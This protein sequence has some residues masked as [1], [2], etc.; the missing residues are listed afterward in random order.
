MLEYLPN[1]LLLSPDEQHALL[2]DVG[3]NYQLLQLVDVQAGESTAILVEISL[4]GGL[5]CL[6]LLSLSLRQ[7]I[8]FSRVLRSRS[9]GVKAMLGPLWTD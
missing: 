5:R 4:C 1:E 6:L 2:H 3:W 7:W 9:K 8:G